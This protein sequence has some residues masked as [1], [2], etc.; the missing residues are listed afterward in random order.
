ML[1]THRHL[2]EFIITGSSAKAQCIYRFKILAAW[3]RVVPPL[4]L[5]DGLEHLKVRRQKSHVLFLRLANL[6]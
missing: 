3:A 4:H 1:A 6:I 2:E 5:V